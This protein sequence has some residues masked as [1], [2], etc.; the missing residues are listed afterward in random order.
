MAS[1]FFFE[2]TE[3][4]FASEVEQYCSDERKLYEDARLTVLSLTGVDP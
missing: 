4:V 3:S 1:F 2:R